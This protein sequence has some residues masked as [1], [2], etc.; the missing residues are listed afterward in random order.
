[1]TTTMTT[2]AADSRIGAPSA[3]SDSLPLLER[4][5]ALAR[6]PRAKLGIFPSPTEH[7]AGERCEREL[8]IKRDDLNAPNYGGNKVRALE[9]LLGSV[10]PGDTIL[11]I[12]GEG[13]THVLVTAAMGARLGARTRAIRWR[14]E[15]NPA[16]LSTAERAEAL[17]VRL[18]TTP[19]PITAYVASLFARRGDVHWVPPGGSCAAGLLGHVNAGQELAGQVARGELPAPARVVVPFGTGGTAAGIALGFAIAGLDTKVIAARVVPG[20]VA[21]R[22]RLHTLAR[23]CAALI[24]RHERCAPPE[25]R[26]ERIEIVNDVYGGAYGRPLP[27]ATAAAARLHATTGIALD[28]SYSAKAWLA[29]LRL[30]PGGPI[31]FWLTYGG[32]TA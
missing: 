25:L 30:P 1:M 12:G 6:L 7:L 3:D 24:A 28:G 9:F 17:C 14:H 18:R 23:G 15:M 13:S 32:G 4:F 11:T 27:A 29:A 10:N 19:G 22:R 31:L 20:I 26:P 8:W 21:S 16:A 5:P 2:T